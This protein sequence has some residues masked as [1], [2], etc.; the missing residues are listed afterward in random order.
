MKKTRFEFGNE[1]EEILDNALNSLSPDDYRKFL[2]DL[3]NR[4][5]EILED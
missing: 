4:C 3:I 2:Q 1:V 5:Q